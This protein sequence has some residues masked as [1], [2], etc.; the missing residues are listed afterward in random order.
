MKVR[1]LPND[2]TPPAG[3]VPL[4]DSALDQLITQ[5]SNDNIPL[6]DLGMSAPANGADEFWSQARRYGVLPL[7]I[8]QITQHRRLGRRARGS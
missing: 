7:A 3:L 2:A 5:A 8:Q 6:I 4:A 1:I